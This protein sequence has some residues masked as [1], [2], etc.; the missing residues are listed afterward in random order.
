MIPSTSSSKTVS[1]ASRWPHLKDLLTTYLFIIPAFLLFC[2]FSLFPF[3]KVFQLSV[4]EWD[5]IST[6]M[7]F[8]W[9][10]N[11]KTA[12]FRDAS[13]WI[14]LRNAGVIT[15]LALSI[16]NIL[17][18]MLALIVDREIKGKNFYRVVF[19]LPPVLSGIVVGLVWNWIFDGSHGLLNFALQGVGLGHLARA[20]LADPHTALYSVAVIHMWKGFGWGFVILLAGLQAIPREFSEAAR[21][22]GA[23]EWYIF[24]RIT[25]PLMLPVFFLVSIL[26][27]LGTMQIYDIIVSTTNGGPGYHTEVP[28]TRILAAMVGSS[29]FGY[30]C[31]LGILFGIILLAVSMVQMRLSKWSSR[32]S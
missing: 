29:R 8:V 23:G 5:G 19:Y 15:L 31:S 1:S 21:V 22:D 20:W 16:Q 7:H 11:F 18:L 32:F 25:V 12:I 24:S 4:F 13:W 10:E 17:A 26:T 14:S 30:A 27:V 9:L 6:Q 28:I 3:L 2:V